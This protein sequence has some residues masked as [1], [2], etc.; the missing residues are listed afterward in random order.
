M[1]AWGRLFALRPYL[2]DE[3]KAMRRIRVWTLLLVLILSASLVSAQGGLLATTTQRSNLRS[4]PGTQWRKM[5]IVDNGTAILLDG[6]DPTG[7]WARGILPDGRIGWM[8]ITA[9]SVSVDQVAAL[10]SINCF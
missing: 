9:L 1:G 3:G 6:R 2:C 5:G 7:S 8:V 4:G 10:P